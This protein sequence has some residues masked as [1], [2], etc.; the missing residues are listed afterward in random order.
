MPIQDLRAAYAPFP[1]AAV[2]DAHSVDLAGVSRGKRGV[3]K[4]PEPAI[5]LAAKMEDLDQLRSQSCKLIVFGGIV[6][7]FGPT[8]EGLSLLREEN[9]DYWALY[10]IVLNPFQQELTRLRPAKVEEYKSP[11]TIIK[12][13]GLGLKAMPTFLFFKTTDPKEIY[14]SVRRIAAASPAFELTVDRLRRYRGN[15]WDRISEEMNGSQKSPRAG[16]ALRDRMAAWL[17]W[18]LCSITPPI[19]PRLPG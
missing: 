17:R 15:P 12:E 10:R 6:N 14:E 9:A 1:V 19:S 18:I 13:Q 5:G 8:L 11:S 4:K 7:P 16:P 3:L 2:R